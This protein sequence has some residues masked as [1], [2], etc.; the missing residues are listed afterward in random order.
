MVA[1]VAG[2]GRARRPALRYVCNFLLTA[3][4]GGAAAEGPIQRGC[5]GAVV[6]VCRSAGRGR[7]QVSAT[8]GVRV[9][10]RGGRRSAGAGDGLYVCVCAVSAAASGLYINEA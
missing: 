8:A 9:S 3:E 10:C 2:R 7:C 1:R 4:T 5:R 6:R